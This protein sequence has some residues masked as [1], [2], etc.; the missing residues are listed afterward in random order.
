MT[1]WLEGRGSV[2][3]SKNSGKVY[4]KSVL[5]SPKQQRNSALTQ[6]HIYLLY[7]PLAYRHSN[8]PII[9]IVKNINGICAKH[10][11]ANPNPQ[12]L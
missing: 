3:T 7:P 4:N 2:C 12:I 6:P 10:S 5:N 8:L 1:R 11:L 9:K